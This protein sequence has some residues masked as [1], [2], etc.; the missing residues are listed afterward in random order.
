MIYFKTQ[1]VWSRDNAHELSLA[2]IVYLSPDIQSQTNSM[3]GPNHVQH[4]YDMIAPYFPI[5]SS[6]LWAIV[7]ACARFHK[8][9]YLLATD[10]GIRN[11]HD[12][13]WQLWYMMALIQ[14]WTNHTSRRIL[15]RWVAMVW[16]GSFERGD[17]VLAWSWLQSP[18]WSGTLILLHSAL[19]QHFISRLLVIE[20][21]W[22][23]S[24]MNRILPH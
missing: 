21:V 5:S 23:T 17:L 20:W 8:N 24:L 2:N 11:L 13:T 22:S 18:Y 7:R 9:V 12:N 6:I 1:T 19:L 14:K 10:R 3:P 15:P 16:Y 4:S